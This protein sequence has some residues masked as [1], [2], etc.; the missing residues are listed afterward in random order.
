MELGSCDVA[1][2]RR[3]EPHKLRGDAAEAAFRVVQEALGERPKTLPPSE[4]TE[5]N[6]DAVERG[7]M[8]GRKGGK[9][10][11]KKLTEEERAKSATVAALARW[12]RK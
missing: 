12:K 7:R 4:R 1:M 2:K 6:P 10:R 8:G 3:T 11:S 9:A 5:K